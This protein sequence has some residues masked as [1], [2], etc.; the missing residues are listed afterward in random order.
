MLE[1]IELSNA[2]FVTNEGITIIDAD[3]MNFSNIIIDQKEEN[4]IDIYNG[5]NINFMQFTDSSDGSIRISGMNSEGI[6][7]ENSSIEQADIHCSKS[8]NKDVYKI[9]SGL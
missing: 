1:N 8:I 6:T 5:K 2:S 4:V 9:I 7:F 3:K